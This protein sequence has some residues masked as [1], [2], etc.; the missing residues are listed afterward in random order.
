[1]SI[2]MTITI[3]VP[4]VLRSCC[5]GKSEFTLSARNVRSVL[6]QIERIHPSLYKSVCD[7]TGSVRPHV[8]LF[9]NSSLVRRDRVGLDTS[10]ASGDVLSIFQAV[11]GG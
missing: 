3:Q 4:S 7:E 10:L 2:A 6:E 5:D 8:N 11:S 1:M 9:I